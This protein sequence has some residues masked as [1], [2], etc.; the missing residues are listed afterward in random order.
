MLV[1]QNFQCSSELSTKHQHQVGSVIVPAHGI[2][3]R[4]LGVPVVG[5]VNKALSNTVCTGTPHIAAGRFRVSSIQARV[6]N[7]DFEDVGITTI[8]RT[9]KTSD[10]NRRSALTRRDS[11]GTYST[12][13]SSIS[14]CFLVCVS[15]YNK[16]TA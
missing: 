11:I 13:T 1:P 10:R 7:S 2:G 16:Q 15:A 14:S 5:T 12:A 3:P 4:K 8:N 6:T 9:T